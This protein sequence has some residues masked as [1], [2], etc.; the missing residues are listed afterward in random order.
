MVFFK[1]FALVEAL[2]YGERRISESVVSF[3]QMFWS[4]TV[5]KVSVRLHGRLVLF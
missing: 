4:C 1:D 2:D 5:K 3:L